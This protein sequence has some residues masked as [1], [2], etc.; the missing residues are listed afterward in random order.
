MLQ[1]TKKEETTEDSNFEIE[2]SIFCMFGAF[3]L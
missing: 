2:P 3:G 1:E